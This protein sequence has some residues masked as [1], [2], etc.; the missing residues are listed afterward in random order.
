[1][2]GNGAEGLIRRGQV[3]ECVMGKGGATRCD[4]LG[5]CATDHSARPFAGGRYAAVKRISA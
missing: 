2:G 4:R 5:V 1:M 3:E